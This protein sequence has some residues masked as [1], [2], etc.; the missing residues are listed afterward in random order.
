MK[1]KICVGLVLILSL[2]LGVSAVETTT[3]AA[4]PY[5]NIKVTGFGRVRYSYDRTAGKVNGFSIAQSRFGIT[6]AISPLFSY[7]F[8]VETT[9]ADAENRKMVYDVYVD[10][11]IIP[12]FRLRAGQFKFQFGLEQSIKDA[13]LE[14][15]NK[16][17]VVSNLVK[18]T[19]DIGLQVS[20]DLRL[21]PIGT[22]LTLALLNGSGSNL[23]DENNRKTIV[24]RLSA[25]PFTGFTVGGSLSKGTTG[26]NND[27]KDRAGLELTYE[28]WRL[29]VKAEYIFGKD[30]AIEKNGLYA[31][32]GYNL[33]PS[34]VLL[35]RYDNWNPDRSL[36]GK[37]TFR[38]TFGFN[39]FFGRDVIWRTNY[40]LKTETPSVRN[41]VFMTQLQVNF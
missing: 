35:V 30:K 7:T 39:Y 18:P 17:D 11:A 40:E 20:R 9:N 34:S 21:G 26:V 4:S 19:R 23:D 2:A 29:F 8:S 6:G 3:S 33:F 32:G 37:E 5:P 10:T 15:I 16:S 28:Y 14:F 1:T 13:D 27:V 22:S 25:T 38:W 31:M 36:S 24:G 12:N 41:D